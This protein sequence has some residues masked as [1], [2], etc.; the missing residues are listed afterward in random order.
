[1]K[2]LLLFLFALLTTATVWAYEFTPLQMGEN[3]GIELGPNDSDKGYLSFTP[4]VTGYYVI[5]TTC[6]ESH[7]MAFNLWSDSLYY[8][9]SKPDAL[10]STHACHCGY[11]NKL[12][13]G[14]TYIMRLGLNGD[15]TTSVPAEVVI[16]PGHI[17]IPDPECAEL[18]NVLRP[19]PV[20]AYEGQ[21][22]NLT[23][24]PGVTISGLT[25]TSGGQPVAMTVDE[26]GTVYT[27]TMPDADVVISGSYEMPSLQLGDN[28]IEVTYNGTQYAFVPEESGAYVFSM[29]C[30]AEAQVR[31]TEN[32]D[33]I[34]LGYTATGETVKVGAM[35]KANT[36]YYVVS[37]ANAEDVIEGVILNIAKLELPPIT[38]GEN[39][40]DVPYSN[41]FDYSFTPTE[42]GDYR[43]YT[44]GDAE[45]RP[46]LKIYLGENMIGQCYNGNSDLD[47]TVSL[48]AGV[49]YTVKA[50]AH[51]DM[52][53]MS[54]M[55]LT[56]T[57]EGGSSGGDDNV[58]QMGDNEVALAEEP[59]IYTFTPTESGAYLFTMNCNAEALVAITD[60]DEGIASSMGYAEVPGQTICAGIML[61]AGVT[62]QI[63]T[64]LF[65]GS[66][67][68]AILNIA[69]YEIAPI[70]L[71]ENEIYAPYGTLFEYPFTP[72]VSGEYTFRTIG[73]ASLSPSVGVFLGEDYFGYDKAENEDAE[74]TATLEA[75]V[76]YTVRTLVGCYNASL[77]HLTVVSPLLAINVPES[78]ENGMVTSDKE[79]ASIGE[80]VTLT[81]TPDEGYELENLTVTFTPEDEPSGAPLRL[82]GGNVE[83]TPG[84]NGTYTFEMPAAP[85]TVSATFREA[86]AT[87]V[88]NINVATAKRGQ[89]YNLMGQPV[90]NDYKG[91]VIEDGRKR[92]IK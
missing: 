75:G 11:P 45:I 76:T 83:L 80:T 10:L 32:N 55:H 74:F 42:S 63:A 54:V 46:D 12:Y 61:E 89:R 57:N 19:L 82:R 21:E 29:N 71:G 9:D 34:S 15:F 60:N 51:P 81:V 73:D 38:V 20:V 30:G 86:I 28:E 2:K 69:K 22:V 84:D 70:T 1:M 59:T 68:S 41:F 90:G 4:E 7:Y 79:A 62:C 44:T 77:I 58:L 65:D 27:F 39:V 47:F 16:R 3:N 53:A 33:Y 52:P 6:A 40:I 26:S 36:T 87:G 88:E 37:A 48:E 56:V 64:I 25:A 85:V 14:I 5:S 17:V 35:L 8:A 13:A 23:V 31:I 91:I 18:S 66:V 49:T 72:P 78:F 67:D 24:N 92:V 50:A 43:F